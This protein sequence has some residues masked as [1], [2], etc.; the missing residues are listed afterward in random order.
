MDSQFRVSFFRFE[1]K[2]E[3][4]RILHLKSEIHFNKIRCAS[5][6]FP[7]RLAK[8]GNVHPGDFMFKAIML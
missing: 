5:R 1:Q 3:I 8:A 4:G 6:F 7:N 2:S